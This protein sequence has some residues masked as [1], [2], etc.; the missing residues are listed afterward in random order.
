MS[1]GIV[2]NYMSYAEM[3]MDLGTLSKEIDVN[4]TLNAAPPMCFYKRDGSVIIGGNI[5]HFAMR[6][7]EET[8]IK[9]NPLSCEEHR[10]Y[11]LLSFED[12]SPVEEKEEEKIDIKPVDTPARK[13]SQ[14][15]SA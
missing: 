11:I 8:G 9:L 6:L 4:R 10:A 3:I 5:I 2:K 1:N 13:R 12:Y 7:R 14:R 15:K